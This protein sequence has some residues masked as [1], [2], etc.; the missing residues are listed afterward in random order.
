MMPLIANADAGTRARALDELPEER[1]TIQGYP[2]SSVPRQL[3]TKPAFVVKD[4][5]STSMERTRP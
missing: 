4:I 1:F 5:P 2:V 3:V